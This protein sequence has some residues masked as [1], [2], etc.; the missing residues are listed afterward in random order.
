MGDRKDKHREFKALYES[1]LECD[2]WGDVR[3]PRNP[4]LFVELIHVPKGFRV[5][6]EG[7]GSRVRGFNCRVI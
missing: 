5:R 4:A 3:E 7:S 2:G 6:V 1:A